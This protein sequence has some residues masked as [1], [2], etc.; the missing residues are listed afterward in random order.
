MRRLLPF[1]AILSL[2]P[3]LA[4]A[5]S[6]DG[7]DDT[8]VVPG[9]VLVR[10]RGDAAPGIEA[11]KSQSTSAVYNEALDVWELDAGSEEAA[12]QMLERLRDNPDV[13][14]A[15]PQYIYER[16]GEPSDPLYRT[17]QQVHF[18]TI[19]LQAAWELGRPPNEVLVAVID[20]GVDISHP[21]LVDRIWINANETVDGGDEDGN[22][23]IDDV[24]G[25]SFQS[26]PADGD[27][28]DRDGHGTFGAG[29][30]AAAGDDGAGIAGVAEN[31]TIMPV[32]ALDA[33]GAGQ[34]VQLAAAVRYAAE[35]GADVL[36]MS[37]K[38]KLL[39]DDCPT[40]AIVE[41]A[42]AAAV[43]LG[44]TIV[45]AAGND[46]LRCVGYPASSEYT[47]A[48]GGS[49]APEDT[50]SHADFAQWG[51]E[52]DV[53][54]PAVSVHSTC[55]RT[56]EQPGPYC[57]EEDA[58]ATPDNP[59]GSGDGTSFAT[60]I[61]SGV[62]ALLLGHEPALTPGEVQGRLRDTARPV[63]DEDRINW[64]GAGIVNAGGAVGAGSAFSSLDLSGDD[65]SG[66]SLSVVAGTSCRAEIWRF[67]TVDARSISS[68]AGVGECADFWPPTPGR[69]WTLLAQASGRKAVTVNSWSL[70]SGGLSCTAER[71]SVTA[72]PESAALLNIDCVAEGWVA[73]DL[74]ADAHTLSAT[75]PRFFQQDIR[76]ATT[77]EN[78]AVSCGAA[79]NRSVWYRVEGDV[80]RGIAVD[81]IGSEFNTI[82]AA[83]RVN[84][85]GLEEV[86]C[87]RS[88]PGSTARMVVRTD[89]VSDYL[90]AAGASGP[91]PATTLHLNFSDAHTPANDNDGS[92][93]ALAGVGTVHRQPARGA[94][95]DTDDPQLSCSADAGATLW[96]SVTASGDGDLA[97]DTAGSNYDTA[98]GVFERTPAGLVELACNEDA[99]PGTRTS[100]A[101]WPTQAGREYLVMAGS[102]QGTAAG[103]LRIAVTD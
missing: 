99:E 13:E 47:I 93:V 63:P 6:N 33:G 4:L 31:A 15:Q 50:D 91:S 86:A 101:A 72:G 98:L 71:G 70:Q 80:S 60:P 87:N 22:G 68:T 89:G 74:P 103:A 73:N 79:I 26:S 82:V 96:F 57:N 35:M 17:R 11:L 43:Q 8:N 88:I 1:A 51:P 76:L 52:I 9:E 48:V 41:E 53:A 18:R 58:G 78:P 66:L 3:V 34:T 36:N 95:R 67:P 84:G 90:V 102:F 12:S 77:T 7:G 39:G 37:L 29:L 62:V 44:A 54:A 20:G 55:P 94:W 97:V 100:R 69:P 27:V 5:Q 21:E 65:L 25:C 46:R 64:A 40:D 19:N 81:T 28:G 83:Y 49:G 59:Y 85:V 45:A 23:C 56:P 92:P 16:A 75:L 30:I 2:L 14:L 10:F 61:V 42:L 24:T 38:L 32:R